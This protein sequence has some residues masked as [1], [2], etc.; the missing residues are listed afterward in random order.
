[1]QGNSSDLLVLLS[2]IYAD[3][4][5]DVAGQKNE[6]SAQGFVRST[7]KYWVRTSDVT[8]V[9][10]HILQHLPIFQFNKVTLRVAYVPCGSGNSHHAQVLGLLV[11]A[12][13]CVTCRID[14]DTC[15]RRYKFI[16]QCKVSATLAW[17][18]SARAARTARTPA[19]MQTVQQGPAHYPEHLCANGS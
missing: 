16:S 1:M 5:G 4:R 7:T 11:R 19:R 18:A 17:L 2:N 10:N 15:R 13:T 14:R 3:L 8:S 9:K 6:D 12:L